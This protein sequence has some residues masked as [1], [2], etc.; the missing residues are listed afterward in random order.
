MEMVDMDIIKFWFSG[1]TS[2]S[3]NIFPASKSWMTFDVGFVDF[4]KMSF[5]ESFDMYFMNVDINTKYLERFSTDL[6]GI[7]QYQSKAAGGHFSFISYLAWC[8]KKVVLTIL[9]RF[10]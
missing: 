7:N 8:H 2:R 3:V 10:C 6:L 5:L 9:Y 4:E 1:P